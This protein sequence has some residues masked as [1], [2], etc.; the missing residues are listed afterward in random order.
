MSNNQPESVQQGQEKVNGSIVLIAHFEVKRKFTSQGKTKTTGGKAN[1]NDEY[2]IANTPGAPTT[3]PGCAYC[4]RNLER[5]LTSSLNFLITVEEI[6]S[7][8]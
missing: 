4:G 2:I 1:G 8:F 7:A 5:V 3:F 6:W